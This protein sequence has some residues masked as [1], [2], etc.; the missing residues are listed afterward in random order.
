MIPTEDT[1][2]GCHDISPVTLGLALKSDEAPVH[3]QCT[4]MGFLPMSGEDGTTNLQPC[5][6]NPNAINPIMS[7]EA[8]LQACLAFASWHQ[9]GFR[10]AHSGS[11]QFF[12]TNDTLLLDLPL[13]KNGLYYCPLKSVT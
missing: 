13:Q 4:W 9:E 2:V 5:L 7:P 10:Q 6:V 3:H 8:V 1:L 11:L 12:D